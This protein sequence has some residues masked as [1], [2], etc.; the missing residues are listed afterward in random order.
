M[1]ASSF[2]KRLCYIVSLAKTRQSQPVIPTLRR[3][4]Q[5]NGSTRDPRAESLSPDCTEARH[6]VVRAVVKVSQLLHN[7][8]L[9]CRDRGVWAR[10]RIEHSHGGNEHNPG[11]S[12]CDVVVR[13]E[14]R[15]VAL[16]SA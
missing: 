15:G 9:H 16:A 7:L 4:N 1:T 10:N 11:L 13:L 6:C 3:A 8:D 12:K 14:P 2:R 5:V